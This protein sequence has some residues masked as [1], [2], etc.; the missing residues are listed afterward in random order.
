MFQK[1]NSFFAMTAHILYQNI[2]KKNCATHSSKIIKNIIRKIGFKG[3]LI[4]DDI[5]MKSLKFNPMINALKALNAGC[6]LALYCSGKYN[7][8][9]KFKKIPPIDEF[10]KKNIRIFIS[11]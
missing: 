2:D 8:S 5:E 7:I 6:N 4:S 1:T 9:R 10:T 11:F 3:I